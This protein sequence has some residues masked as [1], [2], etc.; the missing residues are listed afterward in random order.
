ME[1]E[2][3]EEGD[4]SLLHCTDDTTL[5]QHFNFKEERKEKNIIIIHYEGMK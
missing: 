1:E 5:T 4:R 3:E 2:E